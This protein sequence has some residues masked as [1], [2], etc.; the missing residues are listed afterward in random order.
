MMTVYG[1]FRGCERKLT[2]VPERSLGTIQ[3]SSMQNSTIIM[4][5][6]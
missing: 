5:V 6:L 1:K 4:A 2:E 3:S